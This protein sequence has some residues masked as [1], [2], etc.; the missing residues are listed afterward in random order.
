MRTALV[1]LLVSLMASAALAQALPDVVRLNDGSFVR[2]T[3]VE[4]VEGDHVVIQTAT[5]E[6]RSIP[7]AT[8]Q[9]AGPDSV[10]T[11]V[12]APPTTPPQG[13]A[14]PPPAA[15][16]TI[17]LTFETDDEDVMTHRLV[18]SAIAGGWGRRGFVRVDAFEPLCLAPCE[19]DVPPGTYQFGLSQ[20][21]SGNAQR[22]SIV[23]PL[24]TD[25]HFVAEFSSR[26]VERAIGWTVFSLSAVACVVTVLVPI[27]V[28]DFSESTLFTSLGVGLGTLVVGMA[29]GFPLIFLNDHA[30]VRIAGAAV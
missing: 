30:E 16:P 18:G 10:M 29:V 4:R 27:F 2:G 24:S 5:G 22:A 13:Y 15:L 25:T 20:G 28:S 1:A 26:G 7:L 8:V 11:A 12:P 17:H 23:Y 9:Y 21:A 19:I 6:L 14:P 3:I